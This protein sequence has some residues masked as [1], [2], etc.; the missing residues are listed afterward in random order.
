MNTTLP[1][2][3]HSCKSAR[4]Q[5]HEGAI[6]RRAAKRDANRRYRHTLNRITAGFVVD[7]DSFDSE[8]FEVPS[9]SAHDIS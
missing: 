6:G 4:R 9:L 2:V 3:Q 7:A 5:V 1:A 8:T